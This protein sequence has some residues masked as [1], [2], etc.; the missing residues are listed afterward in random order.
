MASARSTSRK[1]PVAKKSATKSTKR[2]NDSSPQ[3]SL[4]IYVHGV[5]QTDPPDEL[6][7]QWDLALFG[8]DMGDGSCMAYWADVV[9]PEVL[10]PAAVRTRRNPAAAD[11][12]A[13]DL[14]AVLDEANIPRARKEDA[15]AL[16]LGVLRDLGVDDVRGGPGAINNKILPLPAFLRKPISRFFIEQMVGDTSAYFFAKGKR[17]AICDRLLAEIDKAGARPV[18]IVAHSHGTIVAYEV[19]S[20]LSAGSASSAGKFQLDALVTLGSPMGVQEVQDWLDPTDP[21]QV[22]AMVRRWRNFSD[23]LDLVALDKGLAGDFEPYGT[24][25]D[26][27]LVNNRTRLAWSFNPHSAVG[28]LAHPKVRAVVNDAMRRDVMSRFVLAR[29]VAQRLGAEPQER[30]SV[31]IEVLEPGYGALGEK[32]AATRERERDE[33]SRLQKADVDDI[34]PLKLEHRI[35]AAVLQLRKLVGKQAEEAARIDPL[36]RFVSARLT[37]A[38]LRE[39]GRAHQEMRIYAVWQSSR[40]S[41]LTGRSMSVLKA[42]AALT[43]FTAD[44]SGITWA[45]LDTG[46]RADH[47]HFEGVIK[48]VWDCT[49]RGRPARLVDHKDPDG[50][51]THVSGIISGTA[52][53]RK[54]GELPRERG[55]APRARLVVYKVLDDKGQGEDAWIIKALDHIA[56]QNANVAEGLAI[57]GLNLSLGGPFDNTVYGCGFSPIC[58][59]LR[60]LWR[61]GVLVVVASGNEAQVQVRTADGNADINNFMSIGDP[62][63]LED[64][65]VVGSVHADKPYLYGVSSFSS[66]GPTADGRAKP[67]VVAPGERISSCNSRF[68][69]E[70][71][72]YYQES[73]TSMAAPHV[74]GLL[75]AF[76][77]VRREYRGRPDEVK[78]IL[79]DACT[80][81][82]R[83]RYHQGRGI[84][85]LMQMLLSV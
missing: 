62:A 39:I 60:R 75:A 19:L 58:V 46:V 77:S 57:H 73:G 9:R 66:R 40:K 35:D 64:C 17:Q 50:H 22:P 48:E 10:K 15:Q 34:P 54:D 6:K 65:I 3:D 45:V 85:N 61:D 78:K 30:H 20:A 41:K 31:L 55:V 79:L 14:D 8:R 49:K 2:Q 24:I 83:D 74:S 32:P 26:E 43:S 13:L 53:Q 42:D 37:A 1:P 69:K 44:G 51:G 52:K 76:L 63:N 70:D 33:Q 36:R 71:D 27:V 47:P 4:V 67:D 38:E 25:E 84:P 12:G 80:D 68:R 82:N 28:Y 16:A 72:W 21:L 56:E 59:E 5:A 11:T 7:L 81:I 29:D 23:P 18:T